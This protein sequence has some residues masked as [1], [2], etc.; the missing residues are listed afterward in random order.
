[1]QNYFTH[2]EPAKPVDFE[3]GYWGTIVDPDGKLRDRLQEREQYL[4]DIK[5]ELAGHVP[6]SGV[7]VRH[8]VAVV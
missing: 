4:D 3:E 7:R 5:Q 6:S 8:R 2:R 1:M